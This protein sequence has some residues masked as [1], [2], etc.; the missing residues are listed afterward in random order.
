MLLLTLYC[1]L[2]ESIHILLITSE[3]KIL[4]FLPNTKWF[5]QNQGKPFQAVGEKRPGTISSRLLEPPKP[6]DPLLSGRAWWP[7]H[8][9]LPFPSPIWHSLSPLQTMDAKKRTNKKKERQLSEMT[10]SCSPPCHRGRVIWAGSEGA[11]RDHTRSQMSHELAA[12]EGEGVLC[13]PSGQ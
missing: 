6:N 11:G 5:S 13:V 8:G 12:A 9:L 7:F 3:R 10:R 2:Y 1:F 4:H